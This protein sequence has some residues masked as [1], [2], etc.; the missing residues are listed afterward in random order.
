MNFNT[1]HLELLSHE[2]QLELRRSAEHN[3]LVRQARAGSEKPAVSA[4][5][6][7]GLGRAMVGVGTYLQQGQEPVSP[8][9]RE[10][11]T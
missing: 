6:L 3:R 7:A 5:L 8:V 11:L 10:K 9:L 1:E 2:R 4:K